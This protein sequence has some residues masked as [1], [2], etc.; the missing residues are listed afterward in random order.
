MLMGDISHT[1]LALP[2][3]PKLAS[4]SLLTKSC[5]LQFPS[6]HSDDPTII[7]GLIP[8]LQVLIPPGPEMLHPL[9][10]FS[11]AVLFFASENSEPSFLGI[12]PIISH[13]CFLA[14]CF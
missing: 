1:K 7:T 12:L 8:S 14:Y 9:I 3:S 13:M 6:T 11:W 4:G 5:S 10:F 2:T